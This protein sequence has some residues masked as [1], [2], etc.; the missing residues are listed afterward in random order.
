MGMSSSPFLPS[1][2]FP[3]RARRPWESP[4]L[5][6][7]PKFSARGFSDSR[8][9][10]NMSGGATI[11]FGARTDFRPARG[12]P[13]YAW[14]LLAYNF[15]VIL[16]GALV[17]ATGSGAGCGGHWPLCNGDVLP[18][19]PQIATVIEFTHRAM[20]GGALITA[21]ILA[22]WGWRVFPARHPARRWALW[23]L[24]FML[25]EALIGAA[26]VLLGHVAKDESVGRVYSL[27]LHLI[28]TFLLLASLALTAWWSSMG[29]A[30][31]APDRS[32][33]ET[34][35]ERQTLQ[36]PRASQ[37]RTELFAGL[38]AL[39]MV[40]M[41]GVITALGDTLFPSHS[42]AEGIAEDFTG[43]ASFLIRLR[44]IHPALGIAAAIFL[45]FVALRHGRGSPVASLRMLSRLLVI[46]LGV[47][48]VMGS[49]TVLLR[50]PVPMQLLH[51]L[52][53]DALWVTTVLFTSERLRGRSLMAGAAFQK[54]RAL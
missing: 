18:A 40:A 54:N 34:S 16:W 50:A 26:L 8:Y 49:L 48:I 25:T 3:P 2:F 47:Q 6:E 42:L 9:S 39:V 10:V 44:V 12:F 7:R 52:V 24:V 27:S 45:A 17:R 31:G 51:L 20:S 11:A 29:L 32:A 22:M 14:S 36:V 15:A 13:A 38:I 53:A 5:W 23:S 46:L 43:T 35:Q 37:G 28:N 30:T 21:A 33:P 19:N 41:A 1:Y 4:A